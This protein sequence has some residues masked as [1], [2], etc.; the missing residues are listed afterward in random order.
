MRFLQGP[1]INPEPSASIV[2]GAATIN[3][4]ID[5]LAWF[6]L[7]GCLAAVLLGGAA[8][9]LS[10][11]GGNFSWAEKGKRGVLSGIVG[12]VIVGGAYAF[13]ST[14]FSIGASMTPGN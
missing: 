11:Q 2:P 14:A 3:Q 6:A 13:V 5:G 10:H 8:W 7:A 12:A 1:V 9:A 4:L